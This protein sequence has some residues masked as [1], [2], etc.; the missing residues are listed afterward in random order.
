M[1]NYSYLSTIEPESSNLIKALQLVQAREGYV[2]DEAI[3]A[4]AEYFSLAPVE[5]EGVLSF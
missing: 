5:V 1:G 4:V 2:S 3:V